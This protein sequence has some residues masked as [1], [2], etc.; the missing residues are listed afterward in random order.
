MAVLLVGMAVMA[1]LMTAA[2]PVWRHTAQRE[3]EEELIWRGNQYARAIGLFQRKYANAMPPNLDL[4]VDQKFLR[5]KYKDP[6][7]DDGEFQIL[8]QATS[9][10]QTPQQGGPT[11]RVQ[12]G[13]TGIGQNPAQRALGPQIGTPSGGAGGSAGGQASAFSARGGIIGVS[14]KS[15][16]TSIRLLNG[17]NHYNEWQ[18]VYVQLSTRPGGMPGSGTQ[19]GQRRPAQGPGW[20]GGLTPTPPGQPPRPGAP[21]TGRP[22]GPGAT[23]IFRPD[24]PPN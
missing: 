22:P 3:K 21:G 2:M 9:Q 12:P 1:V 4:L 18:F 13:Q 8:Y 6:M 17:R 19:P 16:A 10:Q 23:P 11:S 7:S 20:P 24:R 15:T 14:S 5:K